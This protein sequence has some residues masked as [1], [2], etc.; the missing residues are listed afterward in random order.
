MA[1]PKV[2][3]NTNS[4]KVPAMLKYLNKYACYSFFILL[5]IS[6]L[7]SALPIVVKGYN[8]NVKVKVEP[9]SLTVGGEPFTIRV[10]V[11]DVTKLNGW[12]ITLKFDPTILKCLDAIYPSGHVFEGYSTV[13]IPPTIDNNAGIIQYGCSLLGVSNFNGSG[14]LC[15][16]QFRAINNGTTTLSFIGF[17]PP[18]NPTDTY[19]LRQAIFSWENPA[20][21]YFVIGHE[22]EF[23]PPPTFEGSLITAEG[24]VPKNPSI[25]SISVNPTEVF[26][27]QSITISGN[28]TPPKSNV[29]VTIYKG[30]EILT[31][32]KTDNNGHYEYIWK[33]ISTDEVT[34]VGTYAVKSKWD[35]DAT[36]Y[37]NESIPVTVTVKDVKATFYIGR[38]RR[39]SN[40]LYIANFSTGA[41]SFGDIKEALETPYNYTL[42]VFASNITE[43]YAWQIGLHIAN[44]DI[45][46]CTSNSIWIPS[47][48]VFADTGVLTTDIKAYGSSLNVTINV[49]Q[50]APHPS[51]SISGSK[52]AI[53]CAINFT[54]N[55]VGEGYIYWIP[56]NTF[57]KYANGTIAPNRFEILKTSITFEGESVKQPTTISLDV[58]PSTVKVFK[59]V[60][61]SGAIDP[62]RPSVNVTIKKDG[63]EMVKVVTDSNGR[64]QYIWQTDQT[65]EYKI[66]AVWY[67]DK[68]YKGATSE[69]KTVT[70]LEEEPTI[71]YTPYMLGAVYLVAVIGVVVYFKKFRQPEEDVTA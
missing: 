51:F 6:L 61:I 64:Y 47:N 65:G 32:V 44:V 4:N 43:I 7:V 62:V 2:D 16:I 59:N 70:V 25:I 24:V 29:D 9:S 8:E 63:V 67:G 23:E 1:S 39:F 10:T 60:T 35:G 48:G 21:T 27:S 13:P 71:D 20:Q 19:L 26:A 56:E 31:K 11:S 54:C 57:L 28:I 33:T 36:H 53:L 58:N 50:T 69:E 55:D 30:R 12:Q 37:E 41:F 66:Q 40:E 45:A 34:D 68:E 52:V 14:T 38:L 22:P 46:N 18:D 3:L 42:Y 5:T 17:L 49:T 15:Q